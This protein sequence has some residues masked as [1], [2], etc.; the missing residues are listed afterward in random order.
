[1]S[2]SEERREASCEVSVEKGKEF[3]FEGHNVGIEGLQDKNQNTLGLGSLGYWYVIWQ[4][5]FCIAVW[6]AG[7]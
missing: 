1:M 6:G 7:N 3:V 4:A 5:C 2:V